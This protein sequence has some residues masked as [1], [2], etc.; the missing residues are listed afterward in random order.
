MEVCALCAGLFLCALSIEDL[1][2]GFVVLGTVLALV[3]VAGVPWKPYLRKLAVASGFALVSIL[4]LATRVSFGPRVGATFDRDGFGTALVAGSRAVATLSVTLLLVHTTPFPR[5]RAVLARMR[6]PEVFLELLALVHR[7][8]FLLDE[9][10]ARL[11]RSLA[12]RDGG[13][14]GRRR[15]RNLALGASTLFVQ[16]LRRSQRLERGLV[17]RGGMVEGRVRWVEP[18]STDPRLLLAALCLPAGLAIWIR[19]G[20]HV[21]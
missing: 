17:S 11:R 18:L 12:S 10:S 3:A 9:V 4:P 20:C 16:A 19:G 2:A 21:R 1:R 7:E 15:L 13:R 5:L 8:I 14:T 6:L